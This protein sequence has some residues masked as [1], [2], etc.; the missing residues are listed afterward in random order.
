MKAKARW[1][2]GGSEVFA[3]HAVA[4]VPMYGG[5]RLYLIMN[6]I[7]AYIEGYTMKQIR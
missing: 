4:D 6:I 3:Y 2:V 1:I 7:V 5:N